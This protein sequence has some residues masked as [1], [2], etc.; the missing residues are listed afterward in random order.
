[1]QIYI[2]SVEDENS[3]RWHKFI[4]QPFFQQKCIPYTKLGI[5]GAEL[6]AK[7]YF[8]LA[9]KGRSRP[10]SPSMVGCTLS[11]I[12]ALKQFLE[13]A[14]THAVI[15]EDDAIIP[16]TLTLDQLQQ[17]IKC[18]SFDPNLLLSIGGIGMKECQKVRGTI[19][20]QQFLGK[21][22]LHVAPDFYHRICYAVAYIVDREI[23]QTLIDYHQKL[24]AADDWR[25]L[26]DFN[27]S[28]K[29]YMTDLV[30]HP[31]IIAGE[32]NTVLSSIEA[33]R[34]DFS[35]VDHSRYG[36]SLRYNIAKFFYKKFPK[37]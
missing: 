8:E 35:D 23:A 24:R 13:T 28:A 6:T 34:V 2:I 36:S 30:E 4:H 1:M 32:T 7:V 5:K 17:E 12:E 19:L 11:H 33:E 27:S 25:Y 14:D 20:K 3:P 18:L 9:V 10:L 22:I 31:V 16:E 37:V 15:F 21:K 29:I 26:T